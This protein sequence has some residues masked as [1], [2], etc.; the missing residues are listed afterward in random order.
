MPKVEKRT[1]TVEQ[2]IFVYSKCQDVRSVHYSPESKGANKSSTGQSIGKGRRLITI[3]GGG[4]D[5]RKKLLFLIL[6]SSTIKV[7]SIL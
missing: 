7:D 6:N 4:G 3:D 1:T 2:S 5:M